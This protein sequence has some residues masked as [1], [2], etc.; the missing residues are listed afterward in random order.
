MARSC[1]YCQYD[2][3]EEPDNLLGEISEDTDDT[4]VY[5][6]PEEPVMEPDDEPEPAMLV[7]ED[8]TGDSAITINYCPICG[9]DLRV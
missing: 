2:N 4:L 7:L 9:R 3:F 1:P 8:E 5:I 6:T